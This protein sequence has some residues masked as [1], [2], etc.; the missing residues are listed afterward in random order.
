MKGNLVAEK[1]IMFIKNAL[2]VV[3]IAPE[4]LRLEYVSASEGKKFA[5][6]IENMTAELKKLGPLME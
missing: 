1:R 6:V 2:S 4:R 5:S 3:G